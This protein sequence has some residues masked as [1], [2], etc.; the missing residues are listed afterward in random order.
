M[1]LLNAIPALPVT[2]Q[3][4]STSFYRDKLG[5]TV[6]FQDEAFTARHFDP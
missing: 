6:V 4:H 1:K 3:E 5:F 2:D